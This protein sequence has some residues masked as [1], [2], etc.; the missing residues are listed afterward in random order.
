MNSLKQF[1]TLKK[2][3]LSAGGTW[4]GWLLFMAILY[5]LAFGPQEILMAK[6][7]R[8]F[9]S[10]NEKYALAQIA[11]RHDTQTHQQ[12]RLDALRQKTASFITPAENAMG[13]MF[14]ISQLAAEHQLQNFSARDRQLTSLFKEG[15]TVQ[16]TECWQELS[17]AGDFS[18]I[19]S[20]L[21]SLERNQPVIFIENVEIRR[22]AQK[23][24]PLEAK[25]LISYLVEKTPEDKKSKP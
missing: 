6:L 17:F 3:C 18:H 19:A 15:Q 1:S 8:E 5:M 23:N 12:G 20:F 21:N 11:G 24:P 4:A 22:D 16:I 25:A 9:V 13:L 14:H 2:Y 10:S 7:S